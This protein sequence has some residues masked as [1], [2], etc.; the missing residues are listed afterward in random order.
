M[1]EAIEKNI[2]PKV[3]E[4]DNWGCERI[5]GKMKYDKE[6]TNLHKEFLS[7]TRESVR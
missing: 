3:L 2:R 4:M 1:P 7:A 6:L 5:I